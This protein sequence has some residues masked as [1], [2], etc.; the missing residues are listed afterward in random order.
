MQ[1]DITTLT[2]LDEPFLEDHEVP[3]QKEELSEKE[4]GYC[5]QLKP[6][7]EFFYDDERQTH[8]EFCKRCS[9][10]ENRNNQYN[11]IMGLLQ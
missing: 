5:H 1:I 2:M 6:T 3:K 7:S 4:C 8:F 9:H 10:I 11:E